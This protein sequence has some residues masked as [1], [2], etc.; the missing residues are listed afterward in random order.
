MNRETIT[1]LIILVVVFTIGYFFIWIGSEDKYVMRDGCIYHKTK[2][3]VGEGFDI[4]YTPVT[5]DS[6]QFHNYTIE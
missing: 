4:E 1:G 6:S 3:F 2:E 5:C